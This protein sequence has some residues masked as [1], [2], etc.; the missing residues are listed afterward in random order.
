MITTG[1]TDSNGSLKFET[2]VINGIIF[3]EHV[4]YYIQELEAPPGY[5]LDDTRHWFCFC[6]TSDG[7]C[8]V[9]EELAKGKDVL[10][11]PL[12]TI[13]VIEVTNEVLNYNLPSTGGPGIQ[14]LI[15]VSIIFIIIPLVYRFILRRKRE[16]R[17]V[18]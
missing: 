5:R 1:I 15:L 7:S 3:R 10:S 9:Y 18:W 8:D 6:A 4:L 16:R 12:N 14:Y 2:D 17:D 13:G 11:I